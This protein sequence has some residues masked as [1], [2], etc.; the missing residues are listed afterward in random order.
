MGNHGAILFTFHDPFGGTP[1]AKS[2]VY[3]CST[4]W[5]TFLLSLKDWLERDEGPPSPYE[6]KLHVGD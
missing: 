4:K 5:A 3:Y 2:P 6:I 1:L